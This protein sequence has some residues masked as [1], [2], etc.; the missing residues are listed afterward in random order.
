MTFVIVFIILGITLLPFE[1][2]KNFD[3]FT[4]TDV[5]SAV[6][7]SAF[8]DAF[9]DRVAP[10][11]RR[12]QEDGIQRGGRE[13]ISA[14]E[15]V[16]LLARS[17]A[18]EGL[19]E[20]EAEIA[21]SE[22]V[23]RSL[24]ES[25]Q[26]GEGDDAAAANTSTPAE[27]FIYSD[28]NVYIAYECTDSSLQDGFFSP[29]S[30]ILISNFERRIR[31]LKGW[32]ELCGRVDEKYKPMCLPGVSFVSYAMPTANIIQGNVVPTSLILDG[33]GS[34]V[35]PLET[36]LLLAQRHKIVNLLLP[37]SASKMV[38]NGGKMNSV[39]KQVRHIRSAFRFRLPIGTSLDTTAR[40]EKA[41]ADVQAEWVA[42]VSNE[43]LPMLRKGPEHLGS[44][45]LAFYTGTSFD[46]LQVQKALW[47]DITLA[48]VSGV[49]ILLYLLFHTRSVVL[50]F[51]GIFLTVL[52][53]PVAYV[54]SALVFRTTTVSFTFFLALF[55]VVGF[56]SDVIFVYHAFWRSSAAK[57]DSFEDRLGFAYF[58]ASRASLA[59]TATTALSFFANLASSLRALRL[60][61]C[62]MGLCVVVVWL[63]ISIVFPPMCMVDEQHFSAY[64]LRRRKP[65]SPPLRDDDYPQENSSSRKCCER[66][67]RHLHRF[68]RC[69]CAL[70]IFLSM[71]CVVIAATSF[72]MVSDSPSLFP[73]DHNMNRGSKVFDLFT[74][75]S[76]A[77]PEAIGVPPQTERV[78]DEQ[79]YDQK[80]ADEC[81]L[82]WCE[83]FLDVDGDPTGKSCGC[84]RRPKTK[85]ESTDEHE[86]EV[87]QRFVTVEEGP[88]SRFK[89]AVISNLAS[90]E[91]IEGEKMELNSA[92]VPKLSELSP[93]ILHQWESGEQVVGLF[94]EVRTVLRLQDAKNESDACGVEDLCFCGPYAC[95]RLGSDWKKIPPV[96]FSEESRRVEEIVFRVPPAERI[97]IYIP[98]G[99][100]VARSPPS[101]AQNSGSSWKYLQ[102]V[103]LRD[104]WAQRN[105]YSLCT[106]F[107]RHFGVVESRCFMASFRKWLHTEKKLRFPTL[108][109]AF[110]EYSM[111]FIETVRIYATQRKY[112]WI[113][114]GQLRAWFIAVIVDFSKLSS[115]SAIMKYKVLW[116][117]HIEKYNREAVE[118]A[119]PVF[120]ASFTW[121]KVEERMAMLHSTLAAFGIL[122]VLAFAGMLL[123]TWSLALSL[124]TVFSTICVVFILSFF[125]VV[126]MKWQ[127]GLLEI[128]AVI[129][130]IGYSV[131]Y[132]LHIAHKYASPSAFW[133]SPNEAEFNRDIR[134][135][136]TFYAINTIGSA[137][138]GSAITTAGASMFLVFCTLTIFSKLGSM[139]LVVTLV[140][141]IFS[142]GPFPALLMICGPERVGGFCV[143]R[144]D[145]K[146]VGGGPQSMLSALLRKPSR[147]KPVSGGGGCKARE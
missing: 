89:Q 13:F 112:L 21:F 43:L 36:S 58:H 98:I 22:I 76:K 49:F 135:W 63:M 65:T 52:S 129:Y 138:L 10:G 75:E 96:T 143:P 97:W 44:S 18:H 62:F 47:N 45:I 101:F 108:P 31:A 28:K 141:I 128:I 82:Y 39:A 107:P 59:T 2:E 51:V 72:S 134:F 30:L 71:L 4:K 35:V 57:F 114:N 106:E 102:A 124:F 115:P 109:Y 85:C 68:R 74:S 121:V 81:A 122:L 113:D 90:I 26:D 94:N 91:S 14:F 37:S 111:E 38:A 95:S 103:D 20:Y 73:E 9:R 60:F 120:H 29:E 142:L 80:A 33:R 118:T 24:Q 42:F 5:E 17:E 147:R 11:G 6:L 125:V 79:A 119:R 127:V 16:V 78:C 61:G 19:D 105:I 50:S 92:S 137:S 25:T 116:D 88:E 8:M 15:K 55:L 40:R 77:F 86:F 131:T 12:L 56:G 87:V 144:L 83:A 3:S 104:P 64:H 46:L 145:F 123:F 66:W 23:G 139:C 67:T 146:K 133:D 100:N 48:G 110:N 70:P 130:F 54:L 136:R 132:S 140:S 126:V 84:H 1:I 99:I 69:W 34:E 32:E 117:E 41:S 7:L 27:N 53:V 93:I